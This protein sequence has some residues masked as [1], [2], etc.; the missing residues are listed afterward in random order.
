MNISPPRFVRELDF[1]DC[2][3]HRNH[4]GADKVRLHACATIRGIIVSKSL[5]KVLAKMGGGWK[6]TACCMKSLQ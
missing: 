6:V 4:L 2:I 3:F 5:I 1:S